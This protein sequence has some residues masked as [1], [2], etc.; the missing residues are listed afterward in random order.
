MQHPLVHSLLVVQ[1]AWHVSSG[2]RHAWPSEPTPAPVWQHS[3]DAVHEPP[4]AAQGQ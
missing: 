2:D 4:G 1:H 3:F